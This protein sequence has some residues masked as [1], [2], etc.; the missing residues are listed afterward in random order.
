MQPVNP[1]LE[2]RVAAGHRLVVPPVAGSLELAHQRREVGQDQLADRAVGQQPPQADRQRLVVIVLAHQHDPARMVARLADPLVV[3]QPRERRLLHQYM[4]PGG[5]R[6][7]GQVE[8]KSRRHRHHDGV[9][10]RIVDGGAIVAVA[11]DS[12][13]PYPVR[14]RPGPVTAGVAG[15]DVVPESPQVPAVDPGDEAATEKRYM[16]GRRHGAIIGYPPIATR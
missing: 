5:Q 6:S 3:G 15:N 4:L 12:P 9:D 11:P 14:L 8:M 16:D 13:V 10:A 7:E 2:E 1:L